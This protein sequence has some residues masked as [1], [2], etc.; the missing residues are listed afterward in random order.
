VNLRDLLW[1]VLN[2][3]HLA[4][5]RDQWQDRVNDCSPLK[6]DCATQSY[7]SY[8]VNTS[9]NNLSCKIMS[10]FFIA[11]ANNITIYIYSCNK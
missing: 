3:I 10:V 6:K 1:D 8:G 9:K 4:E 11:F 5:S 7:V 2:W